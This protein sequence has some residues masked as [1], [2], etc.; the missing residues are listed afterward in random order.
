MDTHRQILAATVSSI[1]KPGIK[2][3]LWLAHTD[4]YSEYVC[5]N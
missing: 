3:A 2:H 5:V 4:N 1:Y